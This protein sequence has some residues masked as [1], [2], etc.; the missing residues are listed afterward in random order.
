MY[1]FMSRSSNEL[2]ETYSFC[3]IVKKVL[4]TPYED[5]IFSLCVPE[6]RVNGL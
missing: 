2:L 3:R 5:V 4:Y 6:Q 1:C